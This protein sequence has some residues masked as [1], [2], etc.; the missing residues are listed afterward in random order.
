MSSTPVGGPWYQIFRGML[1]ASSAIYRC[2]VR[3]AKR[4]VDLTASLVGILFLAIL[5]PILALAVYLDLRPGQFFIDNDAR[6]R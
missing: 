5:F 3:I 2:P 6:P 4:T 1:P